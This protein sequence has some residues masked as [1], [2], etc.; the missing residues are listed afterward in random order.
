MTKLKLKVVLFSTTNRSIL[1]LPTWN[2]ICLFFRDFL[3]H[4]YSATKQS[5]QSFVP[6]FSVPNICVDASPQA[7][8]RS[9]QSVLV[10]RLAPLL[11]QLIEA[12]SLFGNSNSCYYLSLEQKLHNLHQYGYMYNIRNKSCFV[13]ITEYNEK[14]DRQSNTVVVCYREL[15]EW[16]YKANCSY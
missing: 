10:D 12:L 9:L 6:L 11:Q 16:H 13:I 15:R 3:L 8:P 7:S 5:R 2:S 14:V 4:I 1:P